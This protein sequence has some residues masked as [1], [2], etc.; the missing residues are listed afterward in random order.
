MDAPLRWGVIGTGGIA[1]DF[2]ADLALTGSGTVVAVGSRTRERAHAFADR[3]GVPRRHGSY[4]ALVEDPEV[5]V[6]YVATPHPMH[7]E[8]ALLALRAGK[9]V[10]VEKAFTM[11]AAQARDLVGVARAQGLFL[12]EAMWTRF[13]PHTARLRQLLADGALGE[14]VVVTADHGQWFP[15]DPAHR[16]FDPALGGG[17]L[18]DLGVYPVSFA[19]MVLGAPSGVTALVT[20]AFT[21]VD[22]R[23][24]I[25]LDHP[26]GAHAVLH[27]TSAARTP[28]RAAVVGTDARVEV[29]GDFYAP[30]VIT[31]VPR[32]GEPERFDGRVEGRGLRFEADE[33]ARCLREGLLESP[34]MPL[35]ETVSVMET[36][37]AVLAQARG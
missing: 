35:D 3:F 34:L 30:T 1:G 5:D 24:S 12:M 37:D 8:D 32:E 6:V 19:S 11:D 2:T 27:C 31:L 10:L 36:M 29:E 20:P 23:T 18:L 14:L 28:T 33:V 13:L 26:G 25:L 7:H 21:G 4:A 22:G 16:L 17:A 9:P 15:R